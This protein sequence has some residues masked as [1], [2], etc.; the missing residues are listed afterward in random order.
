MANNRLLKSFNHAIKGLAETFKQEANFRVQIIVAALVI[1]LMAY[2]PLTSYERLLLLIMIV[3]VLVMELV[4]TA[5]EKLSDLLKPRLNNY[6]KSVKN[7]TAAA[8][9]LSSG[10][11]IAVGLVIFWPYFMGLIK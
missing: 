11:A 9:M 4:N 3:L 2:F 8:V 6:V 7:M 1:V 5:L 10:A